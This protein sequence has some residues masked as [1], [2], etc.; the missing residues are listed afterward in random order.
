M[1]A[2]ARAHGI[3]YS[4]LR[5]YIQVL[6]YGVR[7]RSSITCNDMQC[8]IA[9]PTWTGSGSAFSPVSRVS[10][11]IGIIILLWQSPSPSRSPSPPLLF[12][13]FNLALARGC[14]F[15]HTWSSCQ[16]MLGLYCT[17]TPYSVQ[18]SGGASTSARLTD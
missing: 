11:M 14:T 10:G 12:Y 9:H 5:T 8:T 6:V 18:M 3:Q 4:V 15:I 17:P 13:N 16:C 7:R 2:A 1:T